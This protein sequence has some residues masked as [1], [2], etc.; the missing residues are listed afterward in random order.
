MIY[1]INLP[2]HPHLSQLWTRI[3]KTGSWPKGRKAH[4]ACCI[5][6]DK[7]NP[8]LLMVGGMDREEARMRDMWLLNVNQCRWT[9]VSHMCVEADHVTLT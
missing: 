2:A 3:P 8:L 6:Y 5:N 1:L 4:G 9:Q 7:P